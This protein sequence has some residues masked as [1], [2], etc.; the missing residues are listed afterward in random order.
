MFNKAEKN[1]NVHNKELTTIVQVFKHWCHYLEGSGTLVDVITDHRNLQYFSMTKILTQQQAH[2]SEF[3]SQFNLIIHFPPGNLRTKNDVLTH[4]W[5]IYPRE[6]SSN[7]ASINPQNLQPVFTNH[8]LA[9]SLHTTILQGPVLQGSLIMDVECLHADICT[10]L[11]SDPT[12]LKCLSSSA[13]PQWAT[14]PDRLLH[15]NDCIN[16]PDTS[17]Q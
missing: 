2:Y 13:D 4:R 3:L 8:Q 15:C 10:D 9:L 16:I 17:W 12:A 14:S 5:D 6:G 1:Y 11:Q 7:Y